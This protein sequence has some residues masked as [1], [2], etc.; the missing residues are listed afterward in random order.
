M[1]E[2][3]GGQL[4]SPLVAG[5]Q[6]FVSFYANH[7]D[8]SLVHL[9]T[10]KLG[11]KFSTIAFSQANPDT[12]G[13]MAHIFSSTIISDTT[14][15]VL[16]QG[17]FIADSAYTH[18][19]IGNYFEDAQTNQSQIGTGNPNYA[20]YLI[21]DV[22]VS[23]NQQFCPFK[24]AVS[25]NIPGEQIEVYPSPASGIL[26]IH[27]ESIFSNVSIRIISLTGQTILEKTKLNGNLFQLPL[28]EYVCGIYFLELVINR[29]V[30]RKK[31]IAE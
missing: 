28:H 8:T 22:C 3:I 17:S 12:V 20:Y 21:D 7:A 27:T 2:F 5:Q 30:V 25:E 11:I 15:W 14:S 4:S 1:R 10:D 24:T 6:Y 29:Q 16:I 13:N 26:Y 18:F 31:F 19:G 23:T 9:T